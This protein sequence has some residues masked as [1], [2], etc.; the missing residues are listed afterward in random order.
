MNTKNMIEK[1]YGEYWL[2]RYNKRKYREYR[3]VHLQSSDATGY[4]WL[5]MVLLTIYNFTK[6]RYIYLLCITIYYVMKIYFICDLPY[7]FTM[8]NY[9]L[10]YEDLFY[11]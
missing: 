7:L 8:H 6:Y 11:M 4:I 3:K 5:C 9:L 1:I 10:C 2:G